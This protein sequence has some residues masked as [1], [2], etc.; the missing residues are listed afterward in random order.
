MS[1]F[2]Y[3]LHE[4]C[5]VFEMCIRDS[6]GGILFQYDDHSGFVSFA[7]SYLCE[8]AGETGSFAA[9]CNVKLQFPEVMVL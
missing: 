7:F 1:D 6:V 5:G 9:A 8:P 3:P 2:A 4:E